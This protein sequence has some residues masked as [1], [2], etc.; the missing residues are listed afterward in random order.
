M[1]FHATTTRFPAAAILAEASQEDPILTHSPMKQRF[2][3]GAK[4]CPLLLLAR[5]KR[6]P[7]PVKTTYTFAS[8]AATLGRTK[9]SPERLVVGPKVTRL[10]L[11]FY[12]NSL[13]RQ[14]RCD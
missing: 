2:D 11:P 14:R 4:L 12:P 1:P 9:F 6:P 5:R 13:I 7:L 8:D 3:T 10:C